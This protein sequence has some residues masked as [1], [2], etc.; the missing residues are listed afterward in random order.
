MRCYE[1]M[2]KESKSNIENAFRAEEFYEIKTNQL[3]EL[4]LS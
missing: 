2:Y 3:I 4:K 1:Y